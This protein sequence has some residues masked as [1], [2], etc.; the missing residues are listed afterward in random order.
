[1]VTGRNHAGPQLIAVEG[2]IRVGKSTLSRMLAE[3]LHARLVPDTVDNPHLGDFYFE[4]EGAALRTQMYFLL[5][6]YKQ[7]RDLGLDRDTQ[8]VVCDFLFERDHIFASLTLEDEDLEV[9]SRY[10]DL[11]RENLPVPDLV[12]YLQ[13]SPSVLRKRMKKKNDPRERDISDD[14]LKEVVEAYE[15]FFFRYEASDLLVINT[16]EID[17]VER[18]EDLQELFRRLSQPVTGT[19]YFLPLSPE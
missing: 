15:H 4:E 7:L 1:M 10:Y 3:R 17:F 11:F 6:R 16:N 19:Q 12:L 8:P 18:N 14:Y 5:S 2:P 9:Y 13:A